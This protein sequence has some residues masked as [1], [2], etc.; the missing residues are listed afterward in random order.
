MAGAG[1]RGEVG[2]LRRE[3]TDDIDEEWQSDFNSDGGERRRLG[4]AMDGGA[5]V[6]GWQW[7]P[8]EEMCLSKVELLAVSISSSRA[9]MRRTASGRR[10]RSVPW[11]RR[12]GVDRARGWVSRRCG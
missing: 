2:V 12:M 11:C 5:P 6:L 9:Q 3:L 4:F 8:T 7:G 1:C 10:W